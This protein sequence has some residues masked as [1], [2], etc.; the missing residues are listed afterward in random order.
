MW[1][2]KALRHRA[3]SLRGRVEDGL[4]RQVPWEL[5]ACSG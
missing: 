4:D 1:P 3:D 5:F 2:D